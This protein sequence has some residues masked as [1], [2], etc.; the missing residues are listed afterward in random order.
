MIEDLGLSQVKHTRVAD[1]TV[2]EKQRLNVA[3]H[4]QLDTDIV[5]L[6]Q[7]PQSYI[8][9]LLLLRNMFQ[10][11]DGM[12]IFDTF[13]LVEYL[14]QWAARG[15]IVILTIHPPTYEIFTMISKVGLM[16]KTVLFRNLT[17]LQVILLSLGRLMYFGKR[18][19]MLPYFAFIEYPCPA[20]KNPSD[21]YRESQPA[22]HPILSVF[23]LVDLVTLDDLSP[24]A[25]LESSQR[26]EQLSSIYQ[27]KCE[28]LSDPGPP[29]IMPPK[30]RRANILMQIFGLWIRAMIYMYPFNVINWVKLVLLSGAM[31]LCVGAVFVGIRWRYWDKL[32]QRDHVFAQENV[33]DRLGFHHVMM[34]VG[35]WPILLNIVTEVWTSK[36]QVTRDLDDRLYSKFAYSVTKVV[37]I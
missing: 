14:R 16:P 19:E 18:R 15:R 26:V 27:R 25:M 23:I 7:V 13:F 1:L 3:C 5:I 4:L 32:W 31:S 20:Y 12:D 36:P 9:L 6:D 28:P 2:S 21:Y 11:T 33:N 8:M 30:I 10:P 34:V 29:G 22:N 37:V 17:F 35:V 24:E